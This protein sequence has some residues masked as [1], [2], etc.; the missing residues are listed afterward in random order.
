MS[1]PVFHIEKGR[2]RPIEGKLPQRADIDA[3]FVNLWDRVEALQ[4]RMPDD[5]DPVFFLDQR[6]KLCAILNEAAVGQEFEVSS[7]M[8]DV[9]ERRID[10]RQ[11]E[12]R[13]RAF[14]MGAVEGV[15]SIVLGVIWIGIFYLLRLFG[16]PGVEW[17]SKVQWNKVQNINGAIGFALVGFALAV[18]VRNHIVS[19]HYDFDYVRNIVLDSG[20]PLQKALGNLAIVSA[21]ILSV[22]Y[23]ASI[24]KIGE[25]GHILHPHKSI[26][27]GILL[28][29][30]GP[31]LLRGLIGKP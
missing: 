9:T 10:G 3:R 1:D 25:I 21:M 13:R 22:F 20:R 16:K 5:V 2:I 6:E 30:V 11:L 12:I 18:V 8:I 19:Q 29:L 14:S 4:D 15:S 26:A 23:G 31:R 27:P 24:F 7:S 17:I 28:G